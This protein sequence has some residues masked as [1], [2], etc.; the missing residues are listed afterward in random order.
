MK[1]FLIVFLLLISNVLVSQNY[2]IELC[3]GDTIKRFY[4]EDIN[5]F[6]TVWSI[7]PYASILYQDDS[8]IVLLLNQEGLYNLSVY[9]TNEDCK[10]DRDNA[11]IN[12][13]LCLDSYIYIPSAFTPNDDGLNDLFELKVLYIKEYHL[14]IFNRWGEEIF[15]SFDSK[16]LWD[17]KTKNNE[18]IM[19]G[20]YT[21]TFSYKDSQNKLKQIIGK[22]TLLKL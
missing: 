15:E 10:T 18:G 6:T 11:E 21:Y 12:V 9:Y 7:D 16:Y 14:I 4:V 22:I 19:D 17:G 2:T 20:I 5:Y 8:Q 13:V 3:K 1:S